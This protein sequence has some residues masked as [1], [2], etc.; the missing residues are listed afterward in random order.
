MK[1]EPNSLFEV[2]SPDA[3]A[4]CISGVTEDEYVLLWNSTVDLPKNVSE[5]P[6]SFADRCLAK[7]WNTFPDEMKN[8]LNEI[9]KKYQMEVFGD[10]E[11]EASE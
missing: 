3:V 11:E 5:V 10:S 6:D 9:A 4:E 1:I 7:V 2:W 8:H